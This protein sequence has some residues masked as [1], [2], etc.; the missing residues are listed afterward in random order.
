MSDIL[1]LE[2]KE[3]R[4]VRPRLRVLSSPPVNEEPLAIELSF[5]QL[6]LIRRSLEAVRTLGVY[7]PQD[8]LLGDTIH[9]VDLALKKAA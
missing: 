9:L 4:A 2:P 6:A 1:N 8:E 7:P 3:R 5:R